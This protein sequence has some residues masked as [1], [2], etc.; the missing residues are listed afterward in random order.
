[1]DTTIN[2]SPFPF[3]K[4][5]A[6]LRNIIYRLVIVH[7]QCLIVHDMHHQEFQKRRGNGTLQSRSTYLATDHVCSNRSW[8]GNLPQQLSEP[9]L[10]KDPRAWPLLNTT[11]ALA[12]STFGRDMA[13]A[14]LSLD[15]RS[16]EEVASIFYGG[17]TFHFVSMSS[18]VPFMGDRTAETRKYIQRVRLDLTV[19]DRDWAAIFTEHGRPA[20]WNTAFSALA[21][22][23]HV[24]IKNL[25][26][27]IDDE[28][29]GLFRDGLMLRSRP[30]LWLHKLSKLENLE[31]LGVEYFIRKR[32]T[33]HRQP[34]PDI[35]ASARIEQEI[36]RFLA[37]KML[38][39]EADDHS[40]DA[41]QRRRIRGFCA[42]TGHSCD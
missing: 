7:G 39:K 19:L 8:V 41:L 13:T 4:L 35:E 31:M 23:S 29:A 26:V 1:M 11:Y 10:F 22:L 17:N 32:K 42:S 12:F 16:R 34:K 40:P 2:A 24:N 6:E 5:P 3:F 21:R 20:T 15:K 33:G 18:L 30:M 36:W 25:C 38:K 9:C 37:P 27:Q 28:E 14:M